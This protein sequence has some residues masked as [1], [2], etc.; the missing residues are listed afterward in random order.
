[1]NRFFL[2]YD[3]YHCILFR[4]S[5]FSDIESGI[6]EQEFGIGLQPLS[7]DVI[8][9]H[10]ITTDVFALTPS[11][12]QMFDGLTYFATVKVMNRVGLN[13]VVSS[14]SF[15]FDS[16]PPQAGFVHFGL[17]NQVFIYLL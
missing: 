15:V 6:V 14:E 13:R 12:Q 8:A 9:F 16:T 3:L 7:D 5:S 1:M 10:P 17:A 11:N 4:L 2:E